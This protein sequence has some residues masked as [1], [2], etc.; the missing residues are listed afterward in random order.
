MSISAS[1]RRIPAI[2]AAAFALGCC[3]ALSSSGAMAQSVPGDS[4]GGPIPPPNAAGQIAGGSQT[5]TG[6][7]GWEPVANGPNCQGMTLAQ[8]T[9]TSQE[10]CNMTLVQHLSVSGQTIGEAFGMIIATGCT[11]PVNA[12]HKATC[13]NGGANGDR[14]LFAA[15][16]GTPDPVGC[17]QIF[18]VQPIPYAPAL[19]ITVTPISA[20][21]PEQVGGWGNPNAYGA[22]CT[23]TTCTGQVTAMRCN[24]LG[25]AHNAAY[26]NG[27]LAVAQEATQGGAGV[28]FYDLADPSNPKFLSYFNT[29]GTGSHG[30]HHVWVFNG[31]NDIEIAGGA[32]HAGSAT[33]DSFAGLPTVNAGA[34]CPNGAP[35]A[36]LLNLPAYT[37]KRASQDY[38]FPM[39]VDVSNPLCPREV[40]RWYYPGTSVLDPLGIPGQMAGNDQGVRQHDGV[41][42]PSDPTHAFIGMLDGGIM[43]MSLNAIFTQQWP[44]GHAGQYAGAGMCNLATATGPFSYPAGSSGM[45]SNV[46]SPATILAYRGTGFTHTVKPIVSRGLLLDSEEALANNC[47]DGPHRLSVWSYGAPGGGG[48]GPLGV[49]QLLSVSPF[50][51]DTGTEP[52]AASQAG[53]A[54]PSGT[55]LCG[56][57][58]NPNGRYGSHQPN[59]DNPYEPSWHN[60]N[61]V[62]NAEFRGGIRLFNFTNPY[63]TWEM[64]YFIPPYN[65][66]PG[67][68]SKNGSEQ[69]N[70]VYIDDRAFIYINDRFGDGIWVLTSPYVNCNAPAVCH[71]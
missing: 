23:T 3:A 40:A 54:A 52:S 67:A 6:N 17:F 41:I 37:A 9:S 56:Q 48:F 39:I 1:R 13:K 38:Q 49:P 43:I 45:C 8:V 12:Y 27:F 71:T 58:A 32:G 21:V 61:L 34:G 10:A 33:V 47:S 14:F 62:L 31:G 11:G 59:R 51:W 24:N 36:Q 5:N 53:L 19:H 30:T 55:G 50:A 2:L 42:Q 68:L 35:T 22:A 18:D 70:D 44:N 57:I 4:R 65:G 15:N 60:D 20:G 64:A 25:V 16:E 69:I 28:I 26:P 29:A 7:G 63:Q 66:A 46:W